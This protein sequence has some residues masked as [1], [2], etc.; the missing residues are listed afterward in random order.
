MHQIDISR[1]SENTL[2]SEPLQLHNKLGQVREE[3]GDIEIGERRLLVL[4]AFGKGRF[5]HIRVEG[6]G[7]PLVH[8]AGVG[9]RAWRSSLHD[10]AETTKAARSIDGFFF[11]VV[12]QLFTEIGNEIGFK[13]GRG[14]HARTNNREQFPTLQIRL[15]TRVVACLLAKLAIQFVIKN[16]RVLVNDG[17]D[18]PNLFSRLKLL[19]FHVH[20]NVLPHGR[21][22]FG[23]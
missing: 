19:P 1:G 9:A 10:L 17:E 22:S 16:I 20:P 11:F 14:N 8:H 23:M 13:I 4:H 21:S 12:F 15:G 6:G 18:F 5:E 2:R 7:N 3:D